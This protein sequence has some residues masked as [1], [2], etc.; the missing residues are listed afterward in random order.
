MGEKAGRREEKT[1]GER[2]GGK[3]WDGMGIE[4]RRERGRE[5]RKGRRERGREMGWNERK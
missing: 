2:E 1:E 5:G 4:G 3:G